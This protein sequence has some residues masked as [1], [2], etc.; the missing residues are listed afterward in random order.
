M[1]GGRFRAT[2]PAVPASAGQARRF[3][4]SVLV[5]AGLVGLADTAKL[6][7]SELVANAVLHTGTPLEVVVT[8][9]AEGARLEVHDGSPHL[10]TRKHYSTMSGTGRGLVLVDRMATD[11][12][13]EATTGGKVV[14]CRIDRDA[15]PA[16]DLLQ[17]LLEV[18]VL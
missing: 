12:G 5:A 7:V 15:R 3:V 2:F 14:W 17:N 16:F 11:W 9:D 18:D 10:P 13:A 8:V 4:E 6:L 1:T